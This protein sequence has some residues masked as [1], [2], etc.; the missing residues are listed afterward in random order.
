MR[1]P[2]AQCVFHNGGMRI[3]LWMV[4]ALSLSACGGASKPA[5]RAPLYAGDSEAAACM[6]VLPQAG[7]AAAALSQEMRVARLLSADSFALKLPEAPDH[8]SA[9]QLAEWGEQRAKAW[10]AEKARRAQA[11]RE[12]LDRAAEQGPSERVMAGAL[13]GLVFEDVARSLL[14]IEPPSELDNEPEVAQVFRDIVASQARPYLVHAELAYH[15]CAENASAV[16]GMLHW[17]SFCEQRGERLPDHVD[18]KPAG[19]E[20]QVEVEV[21][22]Q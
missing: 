19:D 4:A 5:V 21:A 14:R 9:A 13:L 3:G 18:L 2:Q 11:A 20:V 1:S 15:A 7:G 17:S 8:A 16:D 6:E 12:Q 22:A 10:L